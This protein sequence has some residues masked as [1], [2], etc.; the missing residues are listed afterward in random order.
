MSSHARKVA[1]YSTGLWNL[2]LSEGLETIRQGCFHLSGLEE[3]AIPSSARRAEQFAF[4][5]NSLR[6][7]RFL[8]TAEGSERSM[9]S[10]SGPQT[11][12]SPDSLSDGESPAGERRENRSESGCRRCSSSRSGEISEKAARNVRDDPHLS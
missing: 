6:Q 5:E 7:A 3:I 11:G 12:R 8:G 4:A 1:G 10:G 9:H 2:L